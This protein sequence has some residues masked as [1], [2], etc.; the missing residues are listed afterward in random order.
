MD[1]SLQAILDAVTEVGA[2]RLVIDSLA[3][4]E[5]A[6]APGFRADFREALYRVLAALT[7]TGVTV[8]S[9][10][11]VDESFMEFRFSN[12]LISFLAD[13][14]LWLRYLELEG[15]LHRILAIIKMR[16]STH[17]KEMRE[18]EISHTGVTLTDRALREYRALLTGIPARWRHGESPK[19]PEK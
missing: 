14:I 10:V 17:S 8:L 15:E 9:T 12:Y 18:Y 19:E 2:T 6:L 5:M 7:S 11:E 13:D 16:G 1:E 4:F 3:G